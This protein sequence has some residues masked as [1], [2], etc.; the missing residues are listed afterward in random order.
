M[1]VSCQSCGAQYNLPDDKVRGRKAKVRCKKC[2][3]QIIVDGTTVGEDDDDEATRVM[4]S[5]ALSS[6]GEPMWTVN[7]SDE[8]QLDMTE[9]ELLAGW[10]EGRVTEDAYVWREGMD[11][12]LPILESTLAP[13]LKALA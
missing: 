3:A 13:T 5:P 6:S 2:S 1:K 11:E 7:L 10:R 9:S 4:M 12:W 8:E